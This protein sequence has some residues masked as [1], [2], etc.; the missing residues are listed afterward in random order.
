MYLL[1]CLNIAIQQL[2]ELARS[3]TWHPA[4]RQFFQRLTGLAQVRVQQ[5]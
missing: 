2:P 5:R 3:Y 4:Q 1:A